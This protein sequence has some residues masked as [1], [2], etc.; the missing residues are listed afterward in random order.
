M[1]IPGALRTGNPWG[2]FRL[3]RSRSAHRQS[4]ISD[5]RLVT[6]QAVEEGGDGLDFVVL[7]L[8]A[9]L[10][11]THDGH[12]LFQIPDLTAVEVGWGQCDVAQRCGTEHVLIGSGV[13]HGEATLV[14]F[15]QDI[16]PRLL[17]HAEGEVTLA[18]NVDAVM[19]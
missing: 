19:A 18:A 3:R 6:G 11:V 9:Q 16:G 1:M 12:G 8:T 2:L 13:G 15:R 10:A 14:T 5:L 17:D 4:R 7:E